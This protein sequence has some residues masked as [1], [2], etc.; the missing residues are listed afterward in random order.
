MSRELAG[1]HY[2]FVP[3]TSG[4]TLLLLHGTGGDEHDLLPLGSMIAP[5]DALLS[6]RGTVLENGMPRFF[7]RLREG[8]LDVPDLIA[9]SHDVARFVAAATKEHGLDPTRVVAVG[10]SNGANLASSMMLQSPATLAGAALIRA[11]VP[12][13][14]DRAP[15]LRGKRVLILAGRRDPYSA[16]PAAETL[17]AIFQGA[18]ATVETRFADAGHELTAADATAARA[19]LA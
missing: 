6:P 9:K 13:K 15:D 18:G 1:Y 5:H 4:R 2:E 17:A 19:W 3:G 11:M 12:Y 14:P 7:R 16:S 8:V 10:Y